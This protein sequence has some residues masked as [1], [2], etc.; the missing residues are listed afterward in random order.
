MSQDTNNRH[1]RVCIV[2]LYTITISNV[3]TVLDWSAKKLLYIPPEV[4]YNYK[5]SRPHRSTS[6]NGCTL[7]STRQSLLRLHK[8]DSEDRAIIEIKSDGHFLA[9]Q[10]REINA[11]ERHL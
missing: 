3:R 1:V 6:I 5:T 2:K 8:A 9:N 11:R 4:C 7:F 10:R